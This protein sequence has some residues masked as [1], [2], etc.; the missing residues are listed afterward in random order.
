[1]K[2]KNGIIVIGVIVLGVIYL[3]WGR[4]VEVCNT[5]T[6]MSDDYCKENITF[7]ANKVWI[8]IREKFGHDIIHKCIENSFDE[9]RFSYD[10]QQPN[11]LAIQVYVN[12]I[13]Y[14]IGEPDFVVYFTNQ[15]E[16]GQYNILD[17]PEKFKMLIE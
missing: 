17:N 7:I 12:K 4:S 3:Q 8:G 15:K 5:Q 2:V 9:V 11:E 6:S 14:D 13:G 16:D 1:M 10:L